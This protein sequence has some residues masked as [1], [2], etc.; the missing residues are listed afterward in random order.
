MTKYNNPVPTKCW[1]SYLKAQ[2]FS[3]VRQKSSHHHWK[4]PKC[5]RTIT[6]HGSH[7]EIPR[8]HIRTCLRTLNQTIKQFNDWAEANC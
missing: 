5:K 6:F 2:G 4:R 8:F 3:Y 7:K 1:E